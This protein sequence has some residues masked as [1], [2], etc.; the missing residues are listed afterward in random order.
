MND[1]QVLTRQAEAVTHKEPADQPFCGT[2]AHFADRE[3]T[4]VVVGDTSPLSHT[5]HRAGDKHPD[6]RAGLVDRTQERKDKCDDRCRGADRSRDTDKHGGGWPVNRRPQWRDVQAIYDIAHEMEANRLPFTHFVTIM[7]GSGEARGRK[8]TCSRLIA[9]L[10]Q[11]L[12]RDGHPHYG[13][14]IIE[15]PMDA[16]LHAHHLL[17]V[18]A[19]MRR[20][21][22]AWTSGLADVRVQVIRDIDGLL[23]YLTK[24]RKRLSP[25]FEA[26]LRERRGPQWRKCRPIVGKRWSTTTDVRKLLARSARQ[27]P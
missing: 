10:G 27:A 14:T 17:R 5:S 18:P 7:P 11:V 4:L 8:R 26:Q 20:R 22:E 1:D 16:D 9:H 2:N 24:E 25:D 3:D 19:S 23:A 6:V 21:I 15:H 13:L 12:L